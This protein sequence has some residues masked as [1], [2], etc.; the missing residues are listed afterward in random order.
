MKIWV[1]VMK[2]INHTKGEKCIIEVTVRSL[3]E[4]DWSAGKGCGDEA[5]MK[6]AGEHAKWECELMEAVRMAVI[7]TYPTHNLGSYQ[8][9]SVKKE[10]KGDMININHG[11]TEA[12]VHFRKVFW[13]EC[14]VCKHTLGVWP[15]GKTIGQI[16][17][18]TKSH[19]THE[20]K[21]KSKINMPIELINAPS[22]APL[23]LGGS[24][25]VE[26]KA[27]TKVETKAETKVEPKAEVVAQPV[28]PTA[29]PVPQA[30]SLSKGTDQHGASLSEQK[31]LIAKQQLENWRNESKKMELE[32]P[33][34]E[35]G[36]KPMFRNNRMY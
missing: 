35:T 19:H 14:S 21:L 24:T 1:Y 26:P 23:T 25:K 22:N 34:T 15:A 11:T 20:L 36:P 12:G 3:E 10:K 16:L 18:Y 28:A 17:Q 6:W 32:G 2:Y 27:E 31:K 5:H 7:N 9:L 29:T 13:M 30:L 33:P 8:L 4:P